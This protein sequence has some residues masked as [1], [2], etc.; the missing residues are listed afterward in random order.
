MWSKQGHILDAA[1]NP[2]GHNTHPN[3]DR[4]YVNAGQ[5]VHYLVKLIPLRPER[6]NPAQMNGLKID[7]S[8]V[9]LAR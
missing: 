2:D 7:L 6:I 8:S 1:E 4:V 9:N 3:T 5:V